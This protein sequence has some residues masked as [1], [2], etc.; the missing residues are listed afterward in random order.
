MMWSFEMCLS[1]FYTTQIVFPGLNKKFAIHVNRSLGNGEL[2]NLGH[3][4]CFVYTL[5]SGPHLS[6]H[7]KNNWAQLRKTITTKLHKRR[8]IFLWSVYFLLPIFIQKRTCRRFEKNFKYEISRKSVLVYCA[9]SCG[10][11]HR[12]P[13]CRCYFFHFCSCFA[14]GPQKWRK[15]WLIKFYRKDIYNWGW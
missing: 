15:R 4:A 7:R 2:S 3:Q 14:K 12:K 13:F 11:K 6:P 1:P 9:V 10:L 8:M 5:C